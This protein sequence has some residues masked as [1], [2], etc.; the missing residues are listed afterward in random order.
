MSDCLHCDINALV[1]KYIESSPEPIDLAQ[2]AS[3]IA[4]SLAEFIL[5][6]PESEQA[7]LM[8]DALAHLGQTFLDKGEAVEPGPHG[9][10]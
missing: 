6:A 1:S 2:I 9:A 4:E 8:A 5:A 3:L 7:N 10:H